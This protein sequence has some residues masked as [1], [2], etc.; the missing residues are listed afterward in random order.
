MHFLGP[1]NP[2]DTVRQL[3]ETDPDQAFVEALKNAQRMYGQW[4]ITVTGDLFKI[5]PS[6]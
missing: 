2:N 5:K 1:N 6:K 3:E 4:N